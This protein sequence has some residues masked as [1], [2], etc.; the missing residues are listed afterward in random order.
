MEEMKLVPPFLL[1]NV[2]TFLFLLNLPTANEEYLLKHN[3]NSLVTSVS[4]N[5][6]ILCIRFEID[7]WK[8]MHLVLSDRKNLVQRVALDVSQIA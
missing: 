3:F 5:Y 4:P 8:N 2:I 7:Y 6:V 1:F